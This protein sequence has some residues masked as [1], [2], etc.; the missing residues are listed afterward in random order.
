MR[1]IIIDSEKREIRIAFVKGLEEMQAIVG[2]PIER[3][4][5][6]ENND[7]VY[8]NEEGL[9]GSPQHFFFIHGI[10]PFAGNG[11]IIGKTNDKGDNLDFKSSLEQI[12]DAV[13]FMNKFELDQFLRIREQIVKSFKG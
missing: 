6:L 1:T 5:V 11:F 12:G 3:A 13:V 7:E 4:C 2:G 9:F 8:V 10:M